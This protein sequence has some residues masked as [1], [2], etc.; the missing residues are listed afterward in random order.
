M[1]I[2]DTVEEDSTT[3]LVVSCVQSSAKRLKG[4]DIICGQEYACEGSVECSEVCRWVGFRN[5]PRRR[6]KSLALVLALSG[7]QMI[8]PPKDYHK[9]IMSKI[10]SIDFHHTKRISSRYYHYESNIIRSEVVRT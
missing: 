2:V 9:E 8:N 7:G 5:T 3:S 6:M 4:F 1:N 10:G